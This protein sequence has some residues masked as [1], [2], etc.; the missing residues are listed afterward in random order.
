M[1]IENGLDVICERCPAL[2]VNNH[3]ETY[4]C[5]IQ[6]GLNGWCG[7]GREEAT[8]RTFGF[9]QRN[10]AVALRFIFPNLTKEMTE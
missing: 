1:S 9:I 5:A 2:M 3:K 8:E 10:Q 6:R 7:V 4:L